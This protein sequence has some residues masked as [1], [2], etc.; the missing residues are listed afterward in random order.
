VETAV[1][2]FAQE[3]LLILPGEEPRLGRAAIR[4]RLSDL[5]PAIGALHGTILDFDASGG[6]SYAYG[7]YFCQCRRDQG[8]D[9]LGHYLS[10]L[11]SEGSEWRIRALVLWIDMA[12]GDAATQ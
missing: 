11:S 7:R 8:G 2:A 12:E 1:E 5:L 4:S 9:V 3:G 6:M 10:V